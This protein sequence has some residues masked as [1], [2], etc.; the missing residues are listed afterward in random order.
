MNYRIQLVVGDGALFFLEEWRP[1]GV[2]ITPEVVG[3]FDV[4]V[5]ARAQD[6]FAATLDDYGLVRGY[7]K[8]VD[9]LRVGF[10]PAWRWQGVQWPKEVQAAASAEASS[11]AARLLADPAYR[12]DGQHQKTILQLMQAASR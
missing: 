3:L 7:L 5:H 9:M 2:E 11:R 10:D 6:A 12:T 1:G 8:L 4:P